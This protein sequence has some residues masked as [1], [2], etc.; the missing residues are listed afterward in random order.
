MNPLKAYEYLAAGKPIVS[1]NIAGIDKFQDL[2]YTAETKE[3]FSKKI[4]QALQEDNEELT[5]KRKETVKE[6]TWNYR[7]NEMLKI[8]NNETQ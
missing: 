8:I 1:T 4:R 6:H 3:E 2:I 5:Q 7:V